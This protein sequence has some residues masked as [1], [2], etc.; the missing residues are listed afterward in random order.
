MSYLHRRASKHR[1]DRWITHVLRTCMLRRS[2][3][4]AL[5]KAE[6]PK[7][8]WENAKEEDSRSSGSKHFRSLRSRRHAQSQREEER[9]DQD[10]DNLHRA[11]VFLAEENDNRCEQECDREE[12]HDKAD[13]SVDAAF[14]VQE[15]VLI[16]RCRSL[17]GVRE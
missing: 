6:A 16:V 3:Q 12:G 1:F 11:A 8:S 13:E 17:L 15:Q 9:K 4:I 5:Y 10:D 2:C 14:I 7:S